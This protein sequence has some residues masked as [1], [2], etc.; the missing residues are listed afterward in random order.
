MTAR[1]TV[2]SD[3][4]AVPPLAG[5]HRTDVLVVGA[6]IVGLSLATMLADRGAEV[7]VV[8]RHPIGEGVTGR[9][10]A[11]VTSL[12]QTV[13]A[14]LAARHGAAAA[15]T[16]AQANQDAVAWVR[17]H[18]GPA[19]QDRDA[20]TIARHAQEQAP[21]QA[22]ADAAEAAG[23][24]VQLEGDG[25]GWPGDAV[26]ALRLPDQ[27]QVDPVALLR[28]L[29][30]A[31]PARAQ[32]RQGTVRSVR[33]GRGGARAAGDGWSVRARQVVIAT[34]LPVLDRGGFFALVEPMASYLIA[35]RQDP[36]AVP[37]GADMMIS[38]GS[39]TRS[40]RWAGPADAPVLLV[41]GE[42]HRTGTGGSTLRRYETLE[43]WARDTLD[44]V[45]ELVARWSAED[46]MSADRLPFAGPH[47]RLGGPVH[48]VTGLSKWGF[49]L[50]VASAAALTERLL[51][52]R[53]TPFGELVDPARLPDRQG[54]LTIG[55]SNLEVGGHLAGG[56][57]AALTRALDRTPDEGE[58]SV[59]RC[60]LAVRAASTS[61]GSTCEVSAVCTHLGGVVRWNDGDRT[62]DC[63]LHGSRFETTGEVRHG[64]AIRAL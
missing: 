17:E 50:G 38:A 14:D 10:T 8:A 28:R 54:A 36:A 61:D 23:L 33:E 2:W 7:L 40:M 9:S 24:P 4:A 45:G 18:A 51:E 25:A 12:H 22:E 64:P 49:S 30:D 59:G 52:D 44:G 43:R 31:L 34:G 16:Y 20:V 5:E 48:V 42:G 47:L 39:P 11:K 46:F 60:G 62:W 13:Y 27:L 57:S 15:Q 41:G 35:L 63:P 58:G 1:T 56:W 26:A 21:L 19:G 53:V 3:P 37:V 55:R 6:G 29:A 32:V